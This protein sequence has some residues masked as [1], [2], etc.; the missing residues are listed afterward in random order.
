MFSLSSAETAASSAVLT[1]NQ[2]I[3]R[4]A[5]WPIWATRVAHRCLSPVPFA[6]LSRCCIGVMIHLIGAQSLRY[7]GRFDARCGDP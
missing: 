4:Q 2:W 3:I 6:P 7:V 5:T 1:A